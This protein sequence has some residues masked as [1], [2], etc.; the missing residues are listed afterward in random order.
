MKIGTMMGIH[1][2]GPILGYY[3]VFLAPIGRHFEGK[4]G[5]GRM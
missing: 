1:T 4:E 5:E 3:G 2:L